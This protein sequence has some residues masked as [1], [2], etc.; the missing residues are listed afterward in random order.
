MTFT[1]SILNTGEMTCFEW[2]RP[3]IRGKLIGRRFRFLVDVELDSGKKVTAYCPNPGR[4]EGLVRPG[5][6]VWL[7]LKAKGDPQIKYTWEMVKI[8]HTYTGTNGHIANRLITTLLESNCLKGF[9]NYTE[10]KPEKR[11]GRSRID[12]EIK[13]GAQK[14]L[15]EVKSTS[16]VYPNR[17][18]YFPDSLTLRSIKQIQTL[19]R[20]L[21]KGNEATLVFAVLSAN[22]DFVRPSDIH[23][24]KFASE[25]RTAFAEGL[26]VRALKFAPSPK[27]IKYLGEIPVCLT[28]YDTEE[29]HAW[30]VNYSKYSGWKKSKTASKH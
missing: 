11:I 24:S 15:V 2:A 14:H 28:E 3:L 30:H 10:L 17:C 9:S 1:K 7:S 18:A 29:L 23:D 20:K 19:R 27:G 5:S 13:N 25:L 21:K 6:E 8:G 26:K 16:L 12:F 4:M 22:V